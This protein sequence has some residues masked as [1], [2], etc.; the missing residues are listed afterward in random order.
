MVLVTAAAVAVFGIPLGFAAGRLYR[1]RE[2]SRLERAATRATGS[3]PVA[4]IA[5]R[6]PIELPKPPPRGELAIYNLAGRRVAGGGPTS[7]PSEVRAALRGQ[8]SDD[9]DG[10]RLAV[11]V[12]IHDEERVVGAVRAAVPWSVVT[13]DTYRSWIV[14]ATFGML[15]VALAAALA[16]WLSSRLAVPVHG[17]TRLA[18]GLGDGDFS[19][20]YQPAGLAELDRAGEA[21]N[22]TAARLGDV[23]ARERAFTAD[24]SHQLNTPL[25]SLRLALESAL[26]TPGTDLEGALAAAI[27]E[28]ERLQS[29]VATLLSVARDAAPLEDA[30][31]DVAAVCADVADRGRPALVRAGRQLRLDVAPDLPR[32]RCPPEV[33]REILS[34]LL[35]NATR[36]GAG[37]VTIAARPAG[38]GVV[39][40]VSDDGPGLSGE[41]DRL[42]ERRSPSAAGNGIGLSLARSLAEA[43]EARLRVTRAAPHPVFAL[44]LPGSGDGVVVVP[45]GGGGRVGVGDGLVPLGDAEVDDHR[46]NGDEEEGAGADRAQGEAPVLALLGEVVAEGS[47][48]RPGEDVGDPEPEHLVDPG[49][50]VG[51]R[52]QGDHTGEQQR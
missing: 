27:G 9:H 31:A 8:V 24:V 6:D 44:A 26:L 1:E 20:R 34:V 36:H 41:P 52:D 46:E 19:A 22:R 40:D 18:V 39:V 7:P 28:V 10:G 23:L 3:I 48:E 17:V 49:A 32:V 42:F 25:T 45:V 29:T 16:A 43:H 5:S 13:A 47:A 35:D 2:V 30:R 33:V 37:T 14:M 21:L 38:R 4:G 51:H 12:P 11:A 50:E 15:A